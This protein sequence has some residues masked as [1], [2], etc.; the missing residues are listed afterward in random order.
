MLYH[1]QYE[2]NDIGFMLYLDRLF[3]FAWTNSACYSTKI[4]E[5]L[6]IEDVDHS[7]Y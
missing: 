7:L 6:K 2:R 5:T 1:T 3:P 4:K